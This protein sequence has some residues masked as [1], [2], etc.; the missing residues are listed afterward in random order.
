[1]NVYMLF[2]ILCSPITLRLFMMYRDAMIH[3][4]ID[5]VVD[6]PLML[7]PQGLPMESW[8]AFLKWAISF[9]R[10]DPFVSCLI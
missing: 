1:M 7:S 10:Y 8:R 6:I 5:A 3:K 4:G 2:N 9:R